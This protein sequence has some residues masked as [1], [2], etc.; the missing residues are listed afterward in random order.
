MVLIADFIKKFG[1]EERL[2]SYLSK[3]GSNRGY[4]PYQLKL[5]CEVSNGE[6]RFYLIFDS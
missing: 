4:K 3:A 6:L 2:N 5:N 1:I